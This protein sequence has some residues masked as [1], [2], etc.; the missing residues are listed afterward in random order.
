MSAILAWCLPSIVRSSEGRPSS[1]P[2]EEL[3]ARGGLEVE[4]LCRGWRGGGALSAGPS[5]LYMCGRTGSSAGLKLLRGR[6]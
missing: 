4:E 3:E 1:M 5:P 2:I 6:A